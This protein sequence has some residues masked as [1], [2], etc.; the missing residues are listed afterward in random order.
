M[1]IRQVNKIEFKFIWDEVDTYFRMK[2]LQQANLLLSTL[3]K[4][5]LEFFH[6]KFAITVFIIET[7]KLLH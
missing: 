1:R 5:G 4:E 7:D 2:Y 6:A 3:R